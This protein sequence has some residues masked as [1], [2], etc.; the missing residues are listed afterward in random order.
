MGRPFTHRRTTSDVSN[1]INYATG[2]LYAPRGI[3]F[4]LTNGAS[5]VST[6]YSHSRL[7]PCRTLSNPFQLH[8]SPKRVHLTQNTNFNLLHLRLSHT[9]SNQNVP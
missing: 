6:F 5:F 7:Q 3:L 2:A 1:A 4:P 9:F 8:S